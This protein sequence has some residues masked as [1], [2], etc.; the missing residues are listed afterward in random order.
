ML[1]DQI[2]KY[3]EH[4]YSNMN[5]QTLYKKFRSGNGQVKS[6]CAEYMVDYLVREPRLVVEEDIER[7]I[8]TIELD[9][10]WRLARDS[11]NL[12]VRD[13]CREKIIKILIDD[14]NRPIY[15]DKLVQDEEEI[16][17]EQKVLKRS[18]K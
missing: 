5:Y 1:E 7:F 15:E 16:K 10:V 2:K 9:S 14:E 18:F 12:R 4:K 6:V 13:V 8:G 11:K 17:E 3:I